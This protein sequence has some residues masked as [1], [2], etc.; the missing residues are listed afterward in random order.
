MAIIDE[1]RTRL[2][3]FFAGKEIDRLTDGFFCWRTI[4]NL[5]CLGKCPEHCFEKKGNSK[6]SP[7]FILRDPF[8]DWYE[9]TM[10]AD[11]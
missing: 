2:P 6:N 8:L 7:V 11:A 3:F 10:K 9:S 1:L 5:R 4:Q